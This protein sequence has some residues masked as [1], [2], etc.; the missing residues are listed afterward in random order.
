MRKVLAAI[1]LVCLGGS[2]AWAQSPCDGKIT[3][4]LNH[5]MNAGAVAKPTAGGS[6]VDPAFGTLIT[7]ISNAQPA[8]GTNA[9]IKTTYSTMRGWNADESLI[10][11]WH[12]GGRYELYD[13]DKPSRLL[14]PGHVQH[15]AEVLQTHNQSQRRRH[16]DALS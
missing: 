2:L 16:D 3:D 8:E 14:L 6:Y 4:K 7:R 13:G 15:R 1:S 12:R 9:V 5:P 11:A 10:I